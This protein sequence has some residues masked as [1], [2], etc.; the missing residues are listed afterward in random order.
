MEN[1]FIVPL[2]GFIFTV[3][4]TVITLFF[5][6]KFAEQAKQ[7]EREFQQRNKDLLDVTAVIEIY[8]KGMDEQR[9]EISELRD[10][11]TTLRKDFEDCSEEM[12]R[13]LR[14]TNS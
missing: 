11:V 12:K 13:H 14:G 2:Y 10:V 1:E 3:V 4:S 5:R 9:K 7:K 6:K 8:K